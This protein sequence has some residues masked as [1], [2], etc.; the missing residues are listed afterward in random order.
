MPQIPA[1]DRYLLVGAKVP[2]SLVPG[3]VPGATRDIEG[4]L[5]LD[6]LIDR[7]RIAALWPA[8]TAPAPADRV[9]L[10]GRPDLGRIHPDCPARL[11]IFGER[12]MNTL[13]C[14]DQPD[15]IVLNNGLHVTDPL[16][17]HEDLARALGWGVSI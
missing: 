9:E 1:V 5:A 17:S 11:V 3:A 13:F 12:S 2:E 4:C 16:P 15:R 8:G 7:G 10:G 6:I 14:R